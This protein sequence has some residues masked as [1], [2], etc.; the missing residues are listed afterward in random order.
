M[1]TYAQARISNPSSYFETP[2]HVLSDGKLSREDKVKVL[3]SMAADADQ[4]LEAKS[5][6]LAEANP[7]YNA[8]ELQSAL[9]QLEKTKEPEIVEHSNLQ[10]ARFQRIMV[11][12]TVDQGLNHEIA[13]VAFDMAEKVNGKVFLLN[14]VP[15]SFE[16]EGL[17]APRPMVTAVPLVATDDTQI[18]EDRNEQLAELRAESGSSVETEIEVRSGQIEEVIVEYADDC[19]ADLIVVGSPN[20]SWLEALLDPSISRRVTRSAPCPVLVVPE[21]T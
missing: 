5:G 11:V 21:P 7:K 15:S 1:I 18:I 12:T 13:A 3:K 20:R 2:N 4:K 16:G 8:K 10:N 17:A 14:V 19:D 9:I 6:R